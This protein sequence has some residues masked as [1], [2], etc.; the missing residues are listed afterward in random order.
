MKGAT[1][2]LLGVKGLNRK[3]TIVILNRKLTIVILNRKLTIVILNQKLTIVILNLKVT[4]FFFYNRLIFQIT[5]R[6]SIQK[7][8]LNFSF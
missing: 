4:E 8:P 5:D 2:V 3:L 1:S 7:P 6:K